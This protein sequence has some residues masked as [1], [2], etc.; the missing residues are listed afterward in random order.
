MKDKDPFV[1]VKLRL[2]EI[3][4]LIGDYEF[5]RW[6]NGAS[7]DEGKYCKKLINRFNKALDSQKE[8]KK[9]KL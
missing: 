1:L 3:E 6:K 5:M 8:H 7:S 2:S 4:T 9:P